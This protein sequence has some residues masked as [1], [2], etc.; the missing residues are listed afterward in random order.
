MIPTA[1]Q[2][3]FAQ[4]AKVSSRAAVPVLESAMRCTVPSIRLEATRTLLLRGTSEDMEAIVRSLDQC[5]Q[6]ELAFLRTCT[7]ILE[8]PIQF[9]IQSYGTHN[10][11]EIRQAG[12]VAVA[13]L[14]LTTQLHQLISVAENPNDEQQIVAIK[15]LTDLATDA[16]AI[17]RMQV[18][19]GALN[20]GSR[21]DAKSMESWDESESFRQHLIML[22]RSSVA[23]YDSH[24]VGAMLDCWLL[25][26]HWEDPGFQAL[27]SP[28]PD[29][30]APQIH[31]R[32]RQLRAA[33]ID[34]LVVGGYWSDIA[35]TRSLETALQLPPERVLRAFLQLERRFGLTPGAVNNLLE[36][37]IPALKD[38]PDWLFKNLA[39]HDLCSW[40]RLQSKTK[41]PAE[42]LLKVVFQL[43]QRF[44]PPEQWHSEVEASCVH[45]LRESLPLQAPIV[46][47]VLS[48][49]LHAAPDLT[50]YEP[51]PWKASL[52]QAVE[53]IVQLYMQPW[54]LPPS[55]HQAIRHLFQN[56]NT[57]SLLTQVES[58]PIDH[59]EA[60]A[61]LTS[62][63]DERYQSELATE[64]NNP[65]PLRR[66]VVY[67]LLQ[68]LE[69]VEWVTE[70]AF[71]GLEDS[72]REVKKEAMKAL[73]KSP[74]SL[75][76]QQCLKPLL[77][78][79]SSDVAELAGKLLSPDLA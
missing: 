41:A 46:S 25:A 73:A 15:L 65:S 3:T 42:L 40:L 76:V 72:D 67:L 69:P 59:I 56:F 62:V 34:L 16:G 17:S 43:A 5:S 63:F 32:L 9:A 2:S 79:P 18:K 44:T 74:D 45:A 55:V 54:S 24:K 33:D 39:P 57:Q 50:P 19:L 21:K 68:L 64:L 10:S 7:A 49:G 53:Q 28:F 13:R 61:R 12:L 36:I 30:E 47:L 71:Q 51:P 26:S 1:L 77:S 14:R 22:L 27:F 52:K 75:T 6:D 4:L 66:R 11:S 38:V 48:E 78:D 37:P 8:P 29:P 20:N 70:L 35:S 60:F 31:R 58:W 23:Q